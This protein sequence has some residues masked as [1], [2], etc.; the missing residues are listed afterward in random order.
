ML[1]AILLLLWGFSIRTY[2]IFSLF[3]K[4]SLVFNFSINEAFVKR[5]R[6]AT[7]FFIRFLLRN[8][9]LLPIYYFN[10][11]I[12]IFSRGCFFFYR[13]IRSDFLHHICRFSYL[14]FLNVRFTP[15]HRYFSDDVCTRDFESFSCASQ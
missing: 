11:R 13:I 10:P 12:N 3:L 8:M 5:N 1:R 9:N 2:V 14:I 4:V 6:L 7:I 15:I